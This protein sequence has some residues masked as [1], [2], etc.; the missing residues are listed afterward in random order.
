MKSA[1]KL[2]PQAGK[3]RSTLT[4]RAA[5]GLPA[6]GLLASGL[7]PSLGCEAF[8]ILTSALPHGLHQVTKL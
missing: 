2:A 4:C 3:T 8:H 5:L 6:E 1:D 7:L